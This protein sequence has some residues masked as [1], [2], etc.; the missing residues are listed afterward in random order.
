MKF[1]TRLLPDGRISIAALPNQGH[2]PLHQHINK[3]L[4]FF[5]GQRVKDAHQSGHYPIRHRY[6]CKGIHVVWV[7]IATGMADTPIVSHLV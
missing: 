1:C 5:H 6:H 2:S 3:G 7:Y 4:R